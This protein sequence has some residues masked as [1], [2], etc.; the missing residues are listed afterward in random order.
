MGNLGWYQ[1]I[2]TISKAVG[3]PKNL[4]GLLVGGGI[5]IGTGG[6]LL[7][8]KIIKAVK[9]KIKSKKI[10]YLE[11]GKVFI[12]SVDYKDENGLD[13]RIGDNF[14]ILESDGD[15]TLIEIIGN[16]NNPYFVSGDLLRKIS[17][18]I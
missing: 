13:L 3:G 1:K 9:T 2:T 7:T 8:Q 5:A 6:T 10:P 14:R 4:I 15:A 11:N 17:D 16:N 18:Y 12:V